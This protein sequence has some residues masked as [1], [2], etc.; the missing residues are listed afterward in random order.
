MATQFLSVWRSLTK[1]AAFH[2]QTLNNPLTIF[3]IYLH[4]LTEIR[5][6]WVQEQ[7]AS[8]GTVLQHCRPQDVY[9]QKSCNPP[10][11]RHESE[12]KASPTGGAILFQVPKS[13]DAARY[14]Q[15]NHHHLCI[16]H[17][18]LSLLYFL[19]HIL[20]NYSYFFVLLFPLRAEWLWKQLEF[21]INHKEIVLFSRST[22]PKSEQTQ[23]PWG[24]KDV[25]KYSIDWLVCANKLHIGNS[26]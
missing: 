14:H 18:L 7:G 10:S 3:L 17:Q 4:A 1:K 22:V 6:W 2:T 16:K 19:I 13:G 9:I 8:F 12:P 20:I 26:Q 24:T 5:R 15:R 23:K 21:M 11:G 25:S